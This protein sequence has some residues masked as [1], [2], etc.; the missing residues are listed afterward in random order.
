MAG[1]PSTIRA[2]SG[3]KFRNNLFIV[4]GYI[5]LYTCSDDVYFCFFGVV[6]SYSKFRSGV[7]KLVRYIECSHCQKRY[8]S[9]SKFEEGARA[10]KSVRC[11]E[12]KESFQIV[13]YEVKDGKSEV[14]RFE[15]RPV[16]E[17]KFLTTMIRKA[18]IDD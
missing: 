9:N 13:V 1:L 5:V 18:R 4:I 8:P 14:V 10:K 16:S 3:L 6:R 17:D 15:P 11:P 12:C 7:R 2:I